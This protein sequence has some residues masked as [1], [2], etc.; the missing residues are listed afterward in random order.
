MPH[1]DR[2]GVPIEPFLT[3]QWYVDAKTLAEP[4]IE[5]VRA[6]AH[7]VRA[8]ELGEDLFRLDGEHPA[9]VHLPPAL[10]GPP[11]PG[12]VRAGRQGLR[13]R[14][15]GRGCRRSARALFVEGAITDAERAAWPPIRPPAPISSR[16]IQDVLDTWFSSALW[17]F[18]TLGWPDET[19]ELERYY[20]T[21]VLVTGFDIIFFWVAR[22]MMMG[23]HFTGTS[24]SRPSTSTASFATRRA[25]RCR[26]RRAT[27]S[28][29][30]ELIDDFG[31][32]AVR[33]TMAALATPGRDVKPARARIEG[34]R[35]F[36]TKLWNAARFA[37]M[38]GCEAPAEFDPASVDRDRQP[39]DRHRGDAGAGGDQRRDSQTI[40]SPMRRPRSTASS[41]T[42][43]A[44][45]IWSWSS[46]S[47]P[48]R[49][50]RPRPRRARPP[51][52]SATTS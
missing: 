46:R 9:L 50:A 2:S 17:P 8:E 27:S 22:M 6:G 36:A 47:S 16:A 12:L 1:G 10:V 35:N 37:E 20:P 44:T 41:G 43:I 48:A 3:D 24:R 13:R 4:A 26:S 33:F 18:S 49:T 32:D 23:L 30:L 51:P 31:A 38:N 15:R 7:Q 45:G 21:S 52:S 19:P 11:D 39:L 29:P 34:Y 14:D 5:A 25:R 28:T 40:A 42:P